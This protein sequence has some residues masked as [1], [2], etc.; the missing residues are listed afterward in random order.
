MIPFQLSKDWYEAYWLTP[1]PVPA[2]RPTGA[3]FAVLRRG[4]VALTGFIA[5][6]LPHGGRSGHAAG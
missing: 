6:H 5:G 3:R 4:L 1:D 2:P